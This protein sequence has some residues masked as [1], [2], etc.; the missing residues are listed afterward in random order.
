MPDY[1]GNS[2]AGKETGKTEQVKKKV[3]RVVTTEVV[4]PK[5]SLGR[6]IKDLFIEADF[7]SVIRYVA[8]DILIPSARDM[9]VK[10]S[11]QG[12]ERAI[13]G[14]DP[15]RRRPM[16]GP[17]SNGP[18]V[19]YNNP[20][21][22]T[23]QLAPPR[24]PVLGSRTRHATSDI[25][26]SSRAEAE[27]VLERLNDLIDTYEVASLHD[28]HELVGLPTNHVDNSWG[29]VFLGDTQIRQNRDGYLLD[30]PPA[31]PIN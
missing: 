7:K 11:T 23:G 20:I 10:A 13:Y 29:W 8:A 16:Y 17:M 27:L 14:D 30:L 22:R 25:L 5:K 15:R 28:L 2:R 3:E 6:K 26:L 1:A 4:V 24:S 9:I 21:N 19:T 31:E 12:I 18:R